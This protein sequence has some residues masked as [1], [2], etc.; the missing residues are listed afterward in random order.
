MIEI[1]SEINALS[2][3]IL[4]E[5]IV[6]NT[7]LQN[8]DSINSEV[9]KLSAGLNFLEYEG[10]KIAFIRFYKFA[11]VNLLTKES[12]DLF[13]RI[14]EDNKNIKFFQEKIKESGNYQKN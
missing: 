8:T 10:K 14:E 6:I 7:L 3:E 2:K 4:K 5:E 11:D 9:K 13:K 12:T 1:A